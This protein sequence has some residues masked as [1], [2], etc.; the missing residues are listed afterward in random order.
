MKET[1]PILRGMNRKDISRVYEIECTCF[2]SPWSRFSLLK[3][4]SNDLAHY[5]VMELEGKLI[6]YAGAWIIFEEAH[7]TNVAIMPEFRNRGYGELL[8]RDLMRVSM[9]H[10]ATCMTLEV[11]E[12]NYTAQRLYAKLG[13]RQNGFRPKYYEDSG[14]GAI[15]M[16][17]MDIRSSI[18]DGPLQ[19]DHGCDT[20]HSVWR[21]QE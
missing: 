5:R 1:D 21:T 15:L 12:K 11:R 18:G 20:M 9:E 14:E 19:T 7:V 2:R 13:F 17:N 3:E 4:L 8:M 10:G 6:G 16:W